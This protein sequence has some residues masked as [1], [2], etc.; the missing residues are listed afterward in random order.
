MVLDVNRE[1][2][3]LKKLV[4]KELDLL[5]LENLNLE[6]LNRENLDQKRVQPEINHDQMLILTMIP[7]VVVAAMIC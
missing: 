1:R 4:K 7:Q 2:Q 5:D 3:V 6:N